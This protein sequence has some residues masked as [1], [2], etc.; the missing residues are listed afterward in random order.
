M[1]R[2]MRAED[3]AGL[4]PEGVKLL[5]GGF[6]GVGSPHRLIA[7]IEARGIGG[8]TVVCNDLC[9]PEKGIGRL[10][11]S[12]QVSR[13]IVSHIGLNAV[14]QK[15]TARGE[16]KIVRRCSLPLTAARRVDLVVT[17]MAVIEPNDQGLVLRERGPGISVDDIR[18]ATGAHLTVQG[19]V[20]EMD[21]GPRSR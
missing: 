9:T 18:A 12:G 14:A 13:A 16:P 15:H 7:A 4:I 8:L 21:L 19:E 1:K 20:P 17:E 2:A 10:V 6:M 11:V 3:A 5:V